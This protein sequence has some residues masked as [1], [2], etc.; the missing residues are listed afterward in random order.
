LRLRSKYAILIILVFV[1]VFFSAINANSASN[2]RVAVVDFGV[3]VPGMGFEEDLSEGI[4]DLMINALVNS[5]RFRVFERGKLNSI[6]NEQGFQN[7]SGLVDPSTV[8]QLGKMIGVNYIITGSLTDVSRSGSGKINIAGIG[9]GSSSVRVVLTVRIIDVTTGEILYSVVEKEKAKQSST[10]ISLPIPIG[11]TSSSSISALSAV[12]TICERVVE[13]FI[14]KMDEKIV[15][16][17][18]VPIEGYVVKVG[19]LQS[20]KVVY[21]NL[22]KDSGIHLGDA[23]AI[24]HPGDAIIDPKTKEILDQELMLVGKGIIITIKDNL[25]IVMIK[26]SSGQIQVED[27]IKLEGFGEDLDQEDEIID[28][29]QISYVKNNDQQIK[30]KDNDQISMEETEDN[31]EKN[32]INQTKVS[33]LP[34]P[35]STNSPDEDINNEKNQ[36]VVTPQPNTMVYEGIEVKYQREYYSKDRIKL[37]YTYYEQDGKKIEHGIWKKWFENGNL[38]FEGEYLNGKKNRVWKQYLITG[39]I[40]TQ[41]EYVDNVKEGLWITW[42]DNGSKKIEGSYKNGMKDGVWINFTNSGDKYNEIAYINDVEQPD[43]YIEWDKYG[44]IV[45]TGK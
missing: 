21:I 2:T 39:Q 28:A 15:S 10:S 3:T 23:I 44:N 36:N 24:Y 13:K 8:V 25:S 43:T 40:L 6:V 19:D 26:S 7:L 34:S 18:P 45:K 32:N 20:E 4:T 11:V 38:M 29:D 27:I 16:Q 22:G 30:N 5:G 1:S 37:E 33:Q 9:I 17:G 41:G 42:F 12:N 31:I 35:Q 14:E